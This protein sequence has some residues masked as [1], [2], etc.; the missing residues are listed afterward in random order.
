MKYVYLIQHAKNGYV[1]CVLDTLAGARRFIAELNARGNYDY[2]IIERELYHHFS[3][4][5]R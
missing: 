5:G 1:H 3:E 2:K 4:V